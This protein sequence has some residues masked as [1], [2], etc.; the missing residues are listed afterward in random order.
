VI[1][2]RRDARDTCVSCY[3]QRFG[4]GNVFS[5]D[6]ADCGRRF[7]EI[8]RLA[9]HWRRVLPLSMLTVDYETLIADP[10]GESRRLIE[11]FGLDWEATCLDFHRTERPVFSAA[12]WQVRQP[13]Y[14]RSVGR[15]RCYE[16]HLGPLFHVLAQAGARR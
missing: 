6:L 9:D 13:L 10:E 12:S 7:V 5:Y 15:W 16:R 1:F 3:F 2:C 8:E 14:S 11:F 4:E